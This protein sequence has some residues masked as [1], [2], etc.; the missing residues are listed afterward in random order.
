[1]IVLSTELDSATRILRLRPLVE[2]VT[3]SWEI[4]IGIVMVESSW[5]WIVGGI[6]R[7]SGDFDGAEDVSFGNKCWFS[8]V[9]AGVVENL[10][11]DKVWD[12]IDPL[13]LFGDKVFDGIFDDMEEIVK[14]LNKKSGFCDLVDFKNLLGTEDLVNNWYECDGTCR[15]SLRSNIVRKSSDKV[16]W[17]LENL[18]LCDGWTVLQSESDH[19]ERNMTRAQRDWK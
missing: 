5:E 19:R 18:D 2:S 15:V 3:T 17:N 8:I 16:G 6:I 9:T 13:G 12:E 10:L 4:A 14:N 1:M 11:L 7:I